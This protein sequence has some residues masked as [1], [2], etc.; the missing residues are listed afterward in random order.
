M[1]DGSSC[2]HRCRENVWLGRRASPR[3][4]LKNDDF[5]GSSRSMLVWVRNLEGWQQR[6]KISGHPSS[7]GEAAVDPRLPEP[8]Y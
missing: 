3:S 5:V 1:S 8:L 4:C 6:A 2:E 7:G